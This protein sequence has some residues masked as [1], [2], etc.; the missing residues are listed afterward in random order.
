M[1]QSTPPTQAQDSTLQSQII[2]LI[3]RLKAICAQSGLGNDAGEYK[4]ITQVFLYKFLNDKFT[5]EVKRA[6]SRLA[7]LDAIAL[8]KELESMP[9]EHYQMLLE[10]IGANVKFAPSD[11]FPALFSAQNDLNFHTKLDNAFENIANNNTEIFSIATEGGSKIKLFEPLMP[12]ITDQSKRDGV[13][14]A[15]ISSLSDFDFEGAFSQGYD[16]FAPLFEYLIKDY[17][18][19]NGGKYAEYY[20]PHSVAAIMAQILVGKESYKSVSCYDPSAGSGTLLMSLAH[21]IGQSK[22]SI[23]AQ[24]I[25]QKSSSLLRLNLILNNLAHSIHNITQGNTLTHPR[26]TH[27]SFDFIV[28][29]PPFK[30]DFSE[31]RNELASDKTRFF[32]GVP[33]IPNK[34]KD[35]MAVYL[36][37]FQHLLN[38]LSPTGKAAIVVPTGFITAQS[39][40]EKSIRKHLVDSKAL[41]GCITMPPNIFATTGTN[42]SIVFI[43]KGKKSDFALL[44]DVSKLG[45]KQKIDKNERVFL[46]KDD[47]LKI[48]NAFIESQAIEDFSIQVSLESIAAKN[49]SFSAE[50]YF[51]FKIEHIDMS[52]IE[53][54]AKIK[55]SKESLEALFTQSQDL[56]KQIL[57]NFAK[58]KFN[59]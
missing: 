53:F 17:N 12:I 47:E 4:I 20:T 26:H 41:S 19:D 56:Q 28:S 35:K 24:D 32:A 57:E 45:T 49:Y 15:L 21:A 5:Y 13:A 55:E 16:F 1:S 9:D 18:K 23:Y 30:L 25:S 59:D 39:S 58:I 43:D 36:C 52:E 51:D 6:E 22:C 7:K 40:I 10:D 3:D 8:Y 42:V 14:K 29:N 54:N 37:F 31:Y 33:K 2:A 27:K 38:S 34:D 44:V 48:I 11:T 50:Q 46:S